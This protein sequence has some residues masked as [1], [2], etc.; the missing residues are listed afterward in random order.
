MILLICFCVFESEHKILLGLGRTNPQCMTELSEDMQYVVM[1]CDDKVAL[2]KDTAV[3]LCTLKIVFFKKWVVALATRSP[4][5]IG[6]WAHLN[7]VSGKNQKRELHL[8]KA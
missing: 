3:E 1:Q 4:V 7:G 5:Q 8:W 2:P 6:T